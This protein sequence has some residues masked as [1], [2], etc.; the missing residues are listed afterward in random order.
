M[1]RG[2]HHS[3][4]LRVLIICT[5]LFR[6]INCLSVRTSFDPDEYW[7]SLEV[8]YQRVYGV[9]AL[10]WEWNVGI[11]SAFHPSIFIAL[12]KILHLLGLDSTWMI[13]WSP[14]LL[15]AITTACLVDYPVF[16][17]TSRF[18]GQTY[19]RIAFFAHLMNYFG[20]YCLTRTFSNCM[21]TCLHF[22][23]FLRWT[24]SK[25]ELRSRHD[26]LSRESTAIVL[27]SLSCVCR[28]PSGIIW[29]YLVFARSLSI[30]KANDFSILVF[31][32][33]KGFIILTT[34]FS[35]GFFFD[36]FFYGKITLS[37]IE[38]VKF[39]VLHSGSQIYGSNSFHWYFTSA[40]PV[41]FGL[42]LPFLITSF[43]CPCRILHLLHGSILLVF[44]YSLQNHKEFRFILC[45]L[46]LGSCYAGI[47]L[48]NYI[49]NK[50]KCLEDGKIITITYQ[51][52]RFVRPAVSLLLYWGLNIP[53]V[54][55]ISLFHQSGG[56]NAVTF[57]QN[58]KILQNVPF[59]SVL[60]LLP[61]HSIPFYSYFHNIDHIHLHQLD[62]SPCLAQD[63]VDET[64]RFY[65]N[66]SEWVHLELVEKNST[67]NL[68]RNV[69]QNVEDGRLQKIVRNYALYGNLR[70]GKCYEKIRS[71]GDN[72]SK[73]RPSLIVTS[74]F[75]AQSIQSWLDVNDYLKIKSMRHT[76]GV[77]NARIGPNIFIFAR[78]Q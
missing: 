10:T 44:A 50:V 29:L 43:L 26:Y 28:P 21:E 38:F 73:R 67:T 17:L 56:I 57:I 12:Y 74:E 66:S 35:F 14:R 55:I 48:Y 36:S 62:C 3:R 65:N 24:E 6:L 32:L 8:A 60:V 61:C 11:R 59:H 54:I 42:S 13:I 46:P 47:S 72:F 15:Q 7:Q 58:Y 53:L 18:A 78:R 23:A 22:M 9:G 69:L 75:T 77:H 37:V 4:N 76:I 63:Y 5:V 40:L 68:M 39:N 52:R 16:M 45:V 64:D 41:L 2:I 1:I 49:K 71:L 20:F 51:K 31:F 27:A 19:G 34:I 30:I 33:C 25:N 70:E